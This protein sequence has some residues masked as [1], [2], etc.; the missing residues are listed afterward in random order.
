[1]DLAPLCSLFHCRELL[2][3]LLAVVLLVL[4]IDKSSQAWRETLLSAV[5]LHLRQLTCYSSIHPFI[6]QSP[7]LKV[8]RGWLWQE[9]R[10]HPA[11]CKKEKKK[12]EYNSATQHLESPLSE[13]AAWE[14][15]WAKWHL[16]DVRCSY[17]GDIRWGGL[18][19][20]SARSCSFYPSK[21]DISNLSSDFRR[22]KI[23]MNAKKGQISFTCSFTAIHF[24]RWSLS[25]HL[26]LWCVS[27]RDKGR[28]SC[29]SFKLQ[30][31][32]CSLKDRGVR[33]II[34]LLA[35]LVCSV[36]PGQSSVMTHEITARPAHSAEGPNSGCNSRRQPTQMTLHLYS[37]TLNCLPHHSAIQH[38]LLFNFIDRVHIIL[39]FSWVSPVF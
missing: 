7:L 23:H 31:S 11:S 28:C 33:D 32:Q 34:K 2:T 9:R 20:A 25:Q 5:F 17:S 38:L 36:W 19:C 12:H 15:C 1:M 14:Y 37:H 18:L 21:T 6:C 26:S 13:W 29:C 22:K 8:M 30:D 27:A 4:P 35:Y 10:R 39:L 24:N 16:V 3:C